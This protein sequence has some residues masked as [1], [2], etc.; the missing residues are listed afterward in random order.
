MNAKEIEA[1]IAGVVAEQK[2]IDQKMEA[3][4]PGND[5][6]WTRLMSLRKE[7]TKKLVVLQDKL[8][9]QIAPVKNVDTRSDDEIFQDMTNN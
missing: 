3:L 2:N 5:K 8:I 1:K 9:D 4:A 7:L 6:E